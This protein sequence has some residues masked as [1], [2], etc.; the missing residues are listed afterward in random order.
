MTMRA[1]FRVGSSAFVVAILCALTAYAAD[2]TKGDN[3][4][5]PTRQTVDDTYVLDAGVSLRVTVYGEPD[6]SGDFPIDE[7]GSIRVPLIGPVKSTGLTVKQV[8]AEIVARLAAGY[9][10]DPR[11]TVGVSTYRPFTILGEVNKPGEYAF[12]S[13]MTVLN[14]VG[15]AGGFT[16]RADTGTVYI[17]HKGASSETAEPADNSTPVRPGDTVR[18]DERIF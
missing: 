9:L 3:E 12:Q 17:R 2:R 15:L 5:A 14:A 7:G 13:K 1:S 6:L 11:V 18:V 8:E 10:V 16:Y 4:T